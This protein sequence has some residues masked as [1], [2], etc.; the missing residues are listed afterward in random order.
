MKVV[1]FCNSTFD[2]IP[3]QDNPAFGNDECY[4]IVQ[5]QERVHLTNVLHIEPVADPLKE[6]SVR[7][8]CKCWSSKKALEIAELLAAT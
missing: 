5:D 4:M 2:Q 8:V 1:N 6:E 7:I 3:R